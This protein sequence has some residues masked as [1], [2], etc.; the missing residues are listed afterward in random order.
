MRRRGAD[1]EHAR[2]GPVRGG[3]E[4]AGLL[5]VAGERADPRAAGEEALDDAL[6][7]AAGG[8]GDEDGGGRGAGHGGAWVWGVGCKGLGW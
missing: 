5:R 8:A 6:P 7:D 3:E 2:V 4:L 1:L